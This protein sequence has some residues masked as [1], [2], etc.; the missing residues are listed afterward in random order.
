VSPRYAQSRRVRKTR[1]FAVVTQILISLRGSRLLAKVAMLA[2]ATGLAVG[3][4]GCNAE[5]MRSRER[6]TQAN[7]TPPVSYRSDI[8][9]FMRTYLND[10]TRIRNAAVSEPALKDF[11][12]ASRYAVCLRYNGRNSTGQYAGPKESLVLFRDGRL[13]RIVDNARETCKDA[14]YQPFPELEQLTR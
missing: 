2:L 8:T 12:N 3:L 6:A 5:W 10:P 13:D 4:A 1:A 14:A 9:A 7:T 11:D